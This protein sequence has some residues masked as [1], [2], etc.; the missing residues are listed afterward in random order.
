MGMRGPIRDP[1]DI[2]DNRNYIGVYEVFYLW[3][4]MSDIDLFLDVREV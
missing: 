3:R 4:A 2:D 1:L